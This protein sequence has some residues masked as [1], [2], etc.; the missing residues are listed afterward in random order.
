LIE[1]YAIGL[2]AIN[3]KS[4]LEMLKDIAIHSKSRIVSSQ[5]IVSFLY[6][7]LHKLD[8]SVVMDYVNYLRDLASERVS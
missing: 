8:R 6:K 2:D 3:L 5:V 7:L 4:H 1:K